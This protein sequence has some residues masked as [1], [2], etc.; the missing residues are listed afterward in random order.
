[1]RYGRVEFSEWWERSLALDAEL[2]ALA[3]DASIPP[4]PERRRIDEWSVDAHQRAW[5]DGDA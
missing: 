4:G 5:S 2:A 1:M 3:D